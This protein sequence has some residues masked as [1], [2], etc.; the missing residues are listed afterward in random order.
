[1]DGLSQDDAVDAATIVE[2]LR[3]LVAEGRRE[4]PRTWMPRA[5]YEDLVVD[6]GR[7]PI[8][9]HES[10][11]YLHRHWNMADSRSCK[12]IG[13][14]PKAIVQRLLSR[15][16]NGAMS[17]YYAEEQAFRSHLARSIDAIAYRVDN[18]SYSDQRALL[19]AVREDLIDLARHVEH[20]LDAREAGR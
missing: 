6:D 8:H 5:S 20:R 15:I 3:S 11:H 13:W 18:L 1:M 10:L 9:L 17:H 4:Y 14:G 2:Q 16:V 19:S 7:E 12:G